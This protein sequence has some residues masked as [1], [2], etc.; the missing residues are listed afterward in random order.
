[1]NIY[2]SQDYYIGRG[3]AECCE[4]IRYF[5]DEDSFLEF[6]R[7]VEGGLHLNARHSQEDVA[8]SEMGD[9]SRSCL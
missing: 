2:I 7:P 5:Q 4:E 6:W 3:S 1:M 8:G 9:N